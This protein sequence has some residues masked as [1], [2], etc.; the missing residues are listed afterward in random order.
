MQVWMKDDFPSHYHYANNPRVGS[1]I[2]YEDLHYE[3][4]FY[5]TV[6]NY[7]RARPLPKST[8]GWL[9]HY[10]E[11]NAFFI[12]HGPAFKNGLYV[13][14]RDDIENVDLYPL[15]CKILGVTPLPNNGSL[16][17]IKFIL[18]DEPVSIESNFINPYTVHLKQVK[19]K[20][21][22]IFVSISVACLIVLGIMKF[23]LFKRKR[24]WNRPNSGDPNGYRLLRHA[25]PEAHSNTTRRPYPSKN[26]Q[27][28]ANNMS[29]TG[30]SNGKNRMNK[31][32]SKPGEDGRSDLVHL[33]DEDLSSDENEL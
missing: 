33:T 10:A 16:D 19:P 12:A 31:S 8:H 22:W 11:M 32:R 18:R 26:D 4:M 14:G 20:V 5:G 28:T 15:M 29:T 6:D 7:T 17:R 23:I 2:V 24:Q 3:I 21:I 27:P 25:S 9:N 1:V 30:S 13:M